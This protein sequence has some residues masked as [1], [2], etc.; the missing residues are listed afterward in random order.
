MSLDPDT[1]TRKTFENSFRGYDPMEVQAYLLVIADELRAARDREFDLELRL[2]EAERRVNQA[3]AA[4]ERMPAPTPAAPPPSLED[5]DHGELA[6]LVGDETARVLEA[7]RSG[8]AEILARAV[9][10]ADATV[11]QSAAR[12][13]ARLEVAD[14]EAARLR[15]DVLLETTALRRE[16]ESDVA[17]LRGA[18]FEE[19]EQARRDLADELAETERQIHAELDEAR[20][21]AELDARA[22]ADEARAFRDAVL[23]DLAERRHAAVRQ[24]EQLTA[25]RE[26][27]VATLREAREAFDATSEAFDDIAA[28][29]D[30]MLVGAKAAADIA[31]RRAADEPVPTVDV[32][33]AFLADLRS[34]AVPG[35]DSA[36]AGGDEPEVVTTLF[37]RI[38]ADAGAFI[39]PTGASEPIE[40]GRAS[41]DL[42]SAGAPE[43]LS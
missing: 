6:R 7:A 36:L 41:S 25:A 18:V 28:A 23:G 2:S 11:A 14:E 12:A 21:A 30:Q 34:K 37:A 33:E 31:E 19:L 16:A 29:T 24:I 1:V 17:D 9:A 27:L 40:R 8:A 5:L 38:R 26:H 13:Q 3:R 4:V 20:E 10:E 42:S 22:L 39:E 43:H 15:D 35:R 32:L